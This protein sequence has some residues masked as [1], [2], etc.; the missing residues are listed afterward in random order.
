[1]GLDEA[2]EQIKI[3]TRQL[4]RRQMKWFRRWGQVKW[5]AGDGAREELVGRVLAIADMLR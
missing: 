2:V 3:G 1:M 4:A 5:V